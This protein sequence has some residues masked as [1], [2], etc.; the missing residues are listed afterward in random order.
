MDF[1][2]RTPPNLVSDKTLNMFNQALDKIAKE[3]QSIFRRFYDNI[4][5][6]NLGLC[7][8]LVIIVIFL[9]YRYYKY[10]HEHFGGMDSPNERIARPTL[11]PYYP[12]NEQNSYVNYLP[13]QIPVFVDGKL[14]N[15]IQYKEGQ[16]D[17]VNL[18]P[19]YPYADNSVIPTEPETSSIQYA[20]PYYHG[21]SND[22]SDDMHLDFVKAGQ[23]NLNQFDKIL[24]QKVLMESPFDVVGVDES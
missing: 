18:S 2:S 7:I 17:T 6:P 8:L 20:G 4:I 15:N 11:N 9:L 14:T 12:V 10:H 19:H 16:Y 24:K 1:Y 13:D 21:L 5:Y 22:V 23:E 3:N